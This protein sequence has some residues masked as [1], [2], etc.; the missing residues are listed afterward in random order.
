MKVAFE[1]LK[2][3]FCGSPRIVRFGRYKETQKWLC[4]DCK[5]HFSDNSA[6]P[7]GK[8][9][10]EQVAQALD[11]YYKG[12]SLNSICEHLNQ[13]YGDSPSN[14]AVYAWLERFSKQAVSEAKKYKPNIGDELIADET[15]VKISGKKYWV[16]D[17]MDSDSRYL[18]A[19]HLSVNRSARDIKKAMEEASETAGTVPK[20]VITDGWVGYLDGIELA[21]GSETKHVQSTPFVEKDSTNRIERLQGSLKDRYKVMRGLKKRDKAE[22]FLDGWRFYYNH[23]RPHDS[24][25]NRTPAEAAKSQFPYKDWADIVQQSFPSDYPKITRHVVLTKPPIA[26]VPPELRNLTQPRVRLPQPRIRLPTAPTGRNT[27]AYPRYSRDVLVQ[28]N[29]RG[30]TLLSHRKLKGHKIVRRIRRGK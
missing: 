12:T 1:A 16:I 23:F 21:F 10:A 17:I 7:Y 13:Q 2:C 22:Q 4:R 15:M 20:K 3:K 18:L 29:R 19:S 14:A 24:L 27:P 26:F 30:D 6:L 9:P 28:T 5:R 25:N 11:L 8:L